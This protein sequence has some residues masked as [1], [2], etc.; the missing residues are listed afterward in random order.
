MIA[1]QLLTLS[2]LA[3]SDGVLDETEKN[4]IWSIG[5]E[6]GLTAKEIG[7]ILSSPIQNLSFENMSKDE[8]FDLLYN[9]IVLM[10]VDGKIMDEEIL[11]CQKITQKLGIEL[12]ALLEIY[13]HVH[14]NVKISGIK[15]KLKR[16][17][18]DMF[19]N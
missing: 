6:N 8:K 7:D 15:E 13:P 19:K 14:G 10:K 16:I 17:V 9:T 2:L 5:S 11:F 1:E 18:M 3:Q 4:L 12:R